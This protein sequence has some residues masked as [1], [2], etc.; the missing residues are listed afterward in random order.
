MSIITLQTPETTIKSNPLSLIIVSF[1]IKSNKENK[2]NQSN[3]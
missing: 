2:T 1:K 3:I